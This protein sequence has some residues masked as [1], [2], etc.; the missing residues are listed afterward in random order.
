MNETDRWRGLFSLQGWTSVLI[1]FGFHLTM[2]LVLSMLVAFV[3]RENRRSLVVTSEFADEASARELDASPVVVPEAATN[4]SSSADMPLEG[5]SNL[6]LP[7][8][9]LLRGHGPPRRQAS[10]SMEM[11]PADALRRGSM[12]ARGGGFEARRGALKAR[13]LAA[14]GGTPETERAVQQG[15]AWLAAHQWQDGGWR[16]DLSDG[17]CGGRCGHSGTVA[18]STG[19]TGLAL[20]PFLGAGHTH[21]SG[22]YRDVVRNGLEYL[23]SR[24]VQTPRGADLQEGTMYAQGIA[25]IALCEA[26][27]MTQD[28]TLGES[29]QQAID[30]ICSAQHSEG[31]WRYYPGQPGDTT[32][33]GW[34][35]MA[36]K[37]AALGGLDVPARSVTRGEEFLDTVQLDNG[38]YYGYVRPDKDPG[39]TAIGLLIRMYTGWDRNDPRL[40]EGVDYLAAL[41][42]SPHDVYFDYYAAQVLHHYGGSHWLKWNESMREHLLETQA[43]KGHERGS[44]FFTDEHGSKGGRLYTTAMCVMILEVYYRHMPLYEDRAVNDDWW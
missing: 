26:H 6:R 19:A 34:Q 20:L 11:S 18:T 7:L 8:E 29:A 10:Q 5:T 14:G 2:I 36:L 37:S 43:T 41:G 9:E 22:E 27:A 30:F 31:G 17:P 42:P 44:W 35:M 38:V 40:I 4:E 23:T 39:P 12:R 1:S 24:I 32:V 13:M 21:Q 28:V 33:F 16:F 25:T 15:L 3:P